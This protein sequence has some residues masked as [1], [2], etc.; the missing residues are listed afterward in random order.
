MF[1][2]KRADRVKLLMW[3][4]TGMVLVHKRLEG[5][6]F[7]WPQVQDGV[8]RMS[9]AQLAALFEGLDWRLVRPERA[10][11]LWQRAD[12]REAQEGPVFAGPRAASVIHFG[13]GPCCAM[14]PRDSHCE[15][16]GMAERDD[17]T[18]PDLPPLPELARPQRC[19]A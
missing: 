3:D 19:A 6:K 5:G 14:P 9:S 16:S 15:F 1:R 12:C 17:Q 7:V 2:S 11:R 8:M 18:C 10:R 4:Q 13:H